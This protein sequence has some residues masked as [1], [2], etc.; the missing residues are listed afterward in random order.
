MRFTATVVAPSGP[1]QH[2]VHAADEAVARDRCRR[3]HPLARI[4]FIEKG[5]AKL[6]GASLAAAIADEASAC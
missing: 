1:V 3:A 4:I 5:Y 2:V 6:T